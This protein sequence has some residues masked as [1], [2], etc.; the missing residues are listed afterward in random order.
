[1]QVLYRGIGYR[2]FLFGVELIALQ[3]CVLSPQIVYRSSLPIEYLPRLVHR[4]FQGF[5]LLLEPG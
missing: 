2:Y 1:L 3:L 5:Q 4:I